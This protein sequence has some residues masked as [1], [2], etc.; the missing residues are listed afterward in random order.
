MS[1]ATCTIEALTSPGLNWGNW[2]VQHSRPADDPLHYKDTQGVLL[3]H[4]FNR[5]YTVASPRTMDA[6]RT[7]SGLAMIRHYALNEH[8]M[9][10]K[11][12]KELLGYFVADIERAGPYCMMA[13]VL[14]MA[15]GDPTMIGYLVGNNFGRGFPVYVREFNAN[16][17]ALPALPSTVVKDAASDSE[18]VVR[19][20]DTAKHG[21]W[22]AAI[23]TSLPRKAECDGSRARRLRYRCRNR[24]RR[25]DRRRQDQHQPLPLPVAVVS[26]AIERGQ[27][28]S[29]RATASL[30]PSH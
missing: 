14:A 4:A 3:T 24:P 5:N 22:I 19:R 2:E 28:A 1:T 10:D 30:V 16:Y 9:F 21:T 12:D 25:Q 7:P 18:V 26:R 29:K 6:F 27:A 23:N 11:S 13:E 15:H 17:L 20:I 8:M